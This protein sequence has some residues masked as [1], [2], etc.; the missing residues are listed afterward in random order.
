MIH[1]SQCL[2]N[3]TKKHKSY[4]KLV[5]IS[6]TVE[7]FYTISIDF[8][9]I[10]FDDMNSLLTIFCK[11][12]NWVMI[13]IEK[14][15]YSIEKWIDW[16]LERFQLTNWKISA[17]IISNINFK[18]MFEFWRTF[19]KKFEIDL[20]TFTV[21]HAQI[22]NQSE[23]TNQTMKTAIRF[24]LIANIDIITTLFCL[25]TQSNN[26]SNAFTERSSNEIVYEFKIREAI[27]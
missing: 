27:F 19:F 6:S 16:M 25:Q 26:L 10:I 9:M 1:C 22:D 12:F 3:Q 2:L 4:E 11:F 24:F 15:I 14:S 20:L 23:K 13:V 5:L 21:Y 7:S 17:A 8:I 18:F